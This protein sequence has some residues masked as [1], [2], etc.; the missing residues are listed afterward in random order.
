[1]ARKLFISYSHFDADLLGELR[2]HLRPFE[3]K[4]LI[5]PWFDGYLVPGDYFDHEV[6]KALAASDFIG[7]L[8]TPR[9]LASDYCVDVEMEDAVRRHQTG[10]ARVVPIIAKPCAW[11]ETIL[12]K[13]LA[14]PT[15]G[16]PVTKWDNQDEAWDIVG[17]DLARAAQSQVGSPAAAAIRVDKNSEPPPSARPRPI[18]FSVPRSS[19]PTDQQLDEFRHAAFETIADLFETSIVALSEGVSGRFQRVDAN[20]FIATLY[21]NGSKVGGCTVYTGSNVFGSNGIAYNG[22]DDGRTNAMNEELRVEAGGEGLG[23]LTTMSRMFA[24]DHDKM[25]TAEEGAARFW[26]LFTQPLTY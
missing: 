22:K 5:A 26:E 23:L 8:V 14:T 4:G 6:R 19:K 20:R 3:R 17:R 18:P 13:L 7:L 11:K 2:V 1:M 16:L 21:R 25:L 24:R 12:S 10:Q 9:F 15:D